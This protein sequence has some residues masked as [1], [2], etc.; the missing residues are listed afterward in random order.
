MLETTPKAYGS[1]DRISEW[2]TANYAVA[3][4]FCGVGGLTHGFVLEDFDVVAG[5]DSDES[6][7]YAYEKNNRGAKFVS[8]K[9]E[10]L[11]PGEIADLFPPDKERVLIGCSPCQPYS[12]NNVRR[13]ETDKWRLLDSFVD[14]V[15]EVNPPVISME[16][17]LQLKSF[18]GGHIYA[19]FTQRLEKLGYVVSDYRAF[20]PEYGVPQ[21]RRRLVMFGSKYGPVKL[22]PGPYSKDNYRTV[23]WA[24]TELEAIPAGNAS[25]KDPL[26]VSSNLTPINRRRV[27][28]SVPG[29]SWREWPDELVLA[30]H[31]RGKGKSALSVY[32]RMSWDTPSPTLTTQFYNLGSGRFGHPDEDRAISL[33]EGA[34][35]QSFPSS[36]DFV[37]SAERVNFTKL[38]RQIGNAVPVELGRAIAKSISKHL[39][40]HARNT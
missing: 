40:V 21:L 28:A 7:R 30:C 1:S 23:R 34:L 3:D 37:D 32:G 11:K 38:G 27:R 5:V 33:R 6:C 35:L 16:N 36:Y 8:K 13:P 9:V 19:N 39:L 22:V 29:G 15:E 31:K 24:F 10:D 25:E 17:V 20:C 2:L 14:I 4:I 12:S 18:A 26:H